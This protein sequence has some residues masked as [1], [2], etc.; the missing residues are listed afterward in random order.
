MSHVMARRLRFL[1]PALGLAVLGAPAVAD[2]APQRLGID[3]RFYIGGLDLF[4]MDVAAELGPTRYSLDTRMRTQGLAD[5]LLSSTILS[6]VDG[7]IARGKA[8]PQRYSSFVEGRFGPRS[9]EMTYG[10]DGPAD[11]KVAPS[12]PADDRTPVDDDLKRGTVDPLT[13]SLVSAIAQ[14]TIPQGRLAPLVGAGGA[15]TAGAAP[16]ACPGVVPVFDGRR[17]YDLQFT[18]EGEDKLATSNEAAYGG[19][20]IIC[21]METR[22]I[23]GFSRQWERDEDRDRPPPPKLWLARLGPEGIVLPVRLVA[24]TRWGTAVAHLQRLTADGRPVLEAPGG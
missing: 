13:A 20:A 7:A 12:D 23:A 4:A 11:V 6:K 3:Y 1:L 9:I 24:K 16:I 22:R 18:Y 8:M 2:P 10:P 5:T 19:P 15:S 17:R 21:R 14:S